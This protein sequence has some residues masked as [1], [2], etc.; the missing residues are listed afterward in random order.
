MLDVA[1][2]ITSTWTIKAICRLLLKHVI[3][4]LVLTLNLMHIIWLGSAVAAE[5]YS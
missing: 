2:D 4:H 3:L 5:A 1:L